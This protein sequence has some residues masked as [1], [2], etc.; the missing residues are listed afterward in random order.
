M[1]TKDYYLTLGISRSESASGIRT[2]FRELA[3]HSHLDHVGPQGTSFFQ[4]IVEAHQVLSDP[5]RRRAYNQGLQ[6]AEGVGEPPAAPIITPQ[7]PVAKPLVPEP[8]SLLHG[9]QTVYPSFEPLFHRFRRNFT[10]S[11]VPKAERVESLTL[12]V[13]LSPE[14]ALRGGTISIRVPVFYPC[15]TCHGSG[16]HWSFP[17]TTY[18][19]HGVIEEE[20]FVR[21]RIPSL[22]QDETVVELPLRGL[23]I[24]NFYLRLF[25]RV[26]CRW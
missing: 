22:V 9:F 26:V 18:D 19:G 23:G 17:C 6:H 24:H 13:L 1:P 3:K 14:E 11:G 7:E 21:I 25:I 16:H 10:G 20:E 12:E 15:P 2:A 4:D 5:E 8:M